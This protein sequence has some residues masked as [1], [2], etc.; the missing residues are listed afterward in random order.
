MQFESTKNLIRSSVSI[1]K[2]PLENFAKFR[3]IISVT[4]GPIVS[5]KYQNFEPNF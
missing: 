3:E 1:G 2:G 4:I 5:G